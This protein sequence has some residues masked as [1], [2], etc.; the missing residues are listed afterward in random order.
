[1]ESLDEGLR[2]G[3]GVNDVVVNLCWIIR[4]NGLWDS[5]TRLSQSDALVTETHHYLPT[6]L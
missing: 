3:V 2:C 1:M 6:Y 5:A 4:R